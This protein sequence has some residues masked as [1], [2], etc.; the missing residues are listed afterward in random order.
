[1]LASYQSSLPASKV[2]A[3]MPELMALALAMCLQHAD[4]VGAWAVVDD[5]QVPQGSG[6]MMQVCSLALCIQALLEDAAPGAWH[7]T[8]HQNIIT[9]MPAPRL[10]VDTSLTSLSHSVLA[11]VG[12][13]VCADQSC[14][15]ADRK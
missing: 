14:S 3:L 9:L 6:L 1:M 13:T 5:E 4:K 8:P 11:G 12:T 10:L 2:Q 7:A 15:R